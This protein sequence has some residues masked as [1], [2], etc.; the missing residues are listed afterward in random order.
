MIGQK[1]IFFFFNELWYDEEEEEE[2][3]EGE[4]GGW[5]IRRGM[6]V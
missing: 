4:R 1:R 6:L 3:K 5:K 2:E